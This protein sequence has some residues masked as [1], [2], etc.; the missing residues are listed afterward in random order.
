MASI[1]HRRKWISLGE[2][3][4]NT[5][6]YIYLS[7]SAYLQELL[8]SDEFGGLVRGFDEQRKEHISVHTPSDKGHM[9][10]QR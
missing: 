3:H 9:I 10:W 6:R 2:L 4:N 8:S 1:R 5:L 7:S